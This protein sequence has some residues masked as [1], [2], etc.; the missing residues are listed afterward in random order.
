MYLIYVYAL[1]IYW[2]NTDNFLFFNILIEALGSVYDTP[3]MSH[4]PL[5]PG[6][7]QIDI[8]EID[9]QVDR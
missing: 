5:R 6:D 4:S 8:S 1:D 3:P 2:S 7:G 9:R